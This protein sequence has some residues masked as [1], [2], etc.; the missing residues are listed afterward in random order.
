VKTRGVTK[1]RRRAISDK[2]S[3]YPIAVLEM[4]LY[5]EA[6]NEVDLEHTKPRQR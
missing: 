1:T 5:K 3:D 4:S 6:I 2:D